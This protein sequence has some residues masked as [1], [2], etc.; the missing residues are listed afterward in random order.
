MAV[1]R[2]DFKFFSMKN[3]SRYLRHLSTQEKNVTA[4][5]TGLIFNGCITAPASFVGPLE[6]LRTHPLIII[7]IS[8][9]QSVIM[10]IFLQLSKIRKYYDSQASMFLT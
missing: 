6:I 3:L 2:C 1:Q 9:N 7:L 4:I 10:K 5:L 8:A